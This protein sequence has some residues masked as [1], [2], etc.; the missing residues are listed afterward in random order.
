[1]KKISKL[2][3]VMII[4]AGLTLSLTILRCTKT[5]VIA[6]Q[7]NRA[8]VGTADTTVFSSFYDSTKIAIADPNLVSSIN[9][10]ITIKGVQS[11]IKEYCGIATCHGGTINPKLSTYGEIKSLVTPGNPEG[12]KL[13]E[14]ITTNDLKTAMPPVNATHELSITAKTIIYNWIKNGAKEFPALEDFRPS[15]I[16]ILIQGCSSTNCHNVTTSTGAWARA[17][18][19]PGLITSDT[20]MFTFIRP[21][22]ITYYCLLSNTTLR[23]TVW[24]AYKDSARKF[25]S[26]TLTYA[27]FRPYKTFSA[28]VVKSNVRGPLSSYDDIIFDICYPKGIRSNSSVV[29][30]S[31][32]N[33]Y[34]V[35]GDYLNTT[36]NLIQRIDS[37]LLRANP[38]TGV[39]SLAGSSDGD[40]AYSDGGMTPSDIALVKA[41]YFADPNVPDV[42]K[43]GLNNVGM[44]KYKKTGNTILKK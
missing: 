42:W 43:Y 21:S 35:K 29:Y 2:K 36:S 14:L 28:P 16:N 24:N 10:F 6:N 18:L 5:G 13:W 30:T 41:W 26:D 23:N 11:T 37:T 33:S 17:S 40:M 1:M 44:F 3:S 20:T 19:I 38:R 31:N 34:Y 15:A 22:S 9:D 32:G 12:S 25:Y 4:L 27:S 8:F 7:L 39:Y